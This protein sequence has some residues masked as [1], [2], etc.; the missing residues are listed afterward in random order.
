MDKKKS[1]KTKRSKV[2]SKNNI[3]NDV[4]KN[5]VEDKNQ[6]K[7]S[8]KEKN[9]EMVL[10]EPNMLE[11]NKK[12]KTNNIILNSLCKTL[13]EDKKI[14]H[15]D[16]VLESPTSA[17]NHSSQQANQSFYKDQKDS[18]N[19]ISEN[20]NYNNK[21]KSK[22]NKAHNRCKNDLD[23]VMA[24]ESS[25][26]DKVKWS[27]KK[28]NQVSNKNINEKQNYNKSDQNQNTFF[29]KSFNDDKCDQKIVNDINNIGLHDKHK[30]INDDGEGWSFCYKKSSNKNIGKK[31]NYIKIDQS[32]SRFSDEN[33]ND[34]KCD[35]K[36]AHVKNNISLNNTHK[37]MIDDG[38]GMLE[39]I[40]E[41]LFKLSKDYSLAHC[42]AEDLRMGAGIAVDFKRIFG[43]VGRLVDQKLKIGDVGIVQRHGQFAF[44]LVTKK[45]SNGKPTMNTM[46]KALRSLFIIMKKNNLTKLGIP[47]IGCGL[48]KLDWSD[49]RSLIIDI[50]SGS[51]IDITVCMPSKLI[52]SKTPQRL[53]VHITPSN[54]WEMVAETII[55]LFIDLE[56]VCKK[57]WKDDVV[58]KVD[59]KYP[60]KENLLKDIKNKK[61][62]PGAIAKYIVNNEVIICI[63]VTQKAFYSSLEDGF[64]S[65]DQTLKYYKYLAIQSGPIEPSDNFERISW[66]VLILRSISHSCELWLCGDVN[67]TGVTYYDQYCKNV[68]NS[69]NHSF[70]ISS[71][72]QNNYKYND[73]QHNLNMRETSYQNRRSES[74]RE[75]VDQNSSSKIDT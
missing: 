67:Q 49:T 71:P 32:Q 66:I 17:H 25:S 68:L 35:Q 63:F 44:Y 10:D 16:N 3:K 56:K 28:K 37:S 50:F 1:S 62:K 23:E 9:N 73:N 13:Y 18:K 57:N 15:S 5:H 70:Q 42:V 24:F 34:D 27:D 55:V 72:A 59:T 33:S 19:K 6:G 41:D 46:E 74:F 75:S 8:F 20:N 65:I 54:L 53:N 29:N 40:D 38:D 21:H 58:D 11:S 14:N 12:K 48:D 43:G 61:F 52:D 51:G 2:E 45:Y 7:K 39:E 36:K 30:S 26:N 31:Q 22:R 60:F 64:K 69:M 4:K 47:K